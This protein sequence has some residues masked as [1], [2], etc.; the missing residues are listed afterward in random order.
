MRWEFHV[1]DTIIFKNFSYICISPAWFKS[2]YNCYRPS[3]LIAAYTSV[4][5]IICG[6]Q[7]NCMGNCDV[8]FN[9]AAGR[10]VDDCQVCSNRQRTG[11]GPNN[12]RPFPNERSVLCLSTSHCFR[13][14]SVNRHI[15]AVIR[16]SFECV[17][18]DNC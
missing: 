9:R 2:L 18:H 6:R 4:A 3:S 15:G 16:I 11:H 1:Y 10:Q 13:L 7:G 8:Q 12:N 5:S 17:L 14:Q